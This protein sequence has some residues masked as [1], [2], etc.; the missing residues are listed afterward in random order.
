[1][2]D[3]PEQEFDP[4]ESIRVLKSETFKE[5]FMTLRE[6]QDTDKHYIGDSLP[7]PSLS[8]TQSAGV[9]NDT[10]VSPFPSRADHSHEFKTVYGIYH[11]SGRTC[12]PGASYIN[13]MQHWLG[14]N[15]LASSQ[16]IVFPFNGFYTMEACF[17]VSR[18]GGGNFENE[19]NVSF[20]YRDGSAER[21]LYR[22]SL[23]DI[24]EVYFFN[25]S[26]IFVN[27]TAPSPSNNFQIKLTHNDVA[28]WTVILQYLYVIR[29]GS[30]ESN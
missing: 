17:Y 7:M 27:T 30:S 22:Q 23:F 26:D 19:I 9:E 13:N 1:M 3:A 21:T 24:P 28:S 20:V 12:Y 6:H 2:S 5:S 11:S 10:G 14:R 8:Q 15:M 29:L 25:V 18:D 4:T 16:V